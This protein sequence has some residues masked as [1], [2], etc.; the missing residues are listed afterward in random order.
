MSRFVS[1]I[2]IFVSVASLF[3]NV[4]NGFELESTT[5]EKMNKLIND[6][7]EKSKLLYFFTTWCYECNESLDQI[8]KMQR[9]HKLSKKYN[10]I[11]ISLD[12]N[13]KK[14]EKYSK[15]NEENKSK[16]YYFK[17]QKEIGKFF[18]STKI[19]YDNAVPY[20]CILDH[21]N[22]VI[23]EGYFELGDIEKYLK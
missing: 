16:I 6:E 12:D 17:Q 19:N 1:Y 22:S 10:F 8:S 11:N 15:N 7:R 18:V 5:S 3:A 23:M 4:S 9:D 14:L 21:N 2:I 20:Y 13:F